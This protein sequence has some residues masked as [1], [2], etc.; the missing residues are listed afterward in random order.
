R[1]AEALGIRGAVRLFAA[2][3][4][5]LGDEVA[6]DALED[7]LFVE[8]AELDAGREARGEFDDAVIEEGEAAFDGIGHGD[9]IA[10]AREDIAGKQKR[11]FEILRLVQRM[12]PG[13]AA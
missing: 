10:L 11:G 1:I 9:A 7:V 4:D 12:P 8:A 13:E 5:G 6:R 2:G 3:R